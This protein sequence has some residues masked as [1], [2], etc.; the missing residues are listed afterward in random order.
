MKVI[1]RLDMDDLLKASEEAKR[2]E[3]LGYDGLAA[4]EFAHDTLLRLAIAAV[5]TER[6]SLESR[7]AIAFPRSP[8]VMAG[9]AWDMQIYSKGRF[10]LGLG[11][12]VKAH[13]I[14]RFGIP[15]SAPGPKFRD[16]VLALRAIWDSWQDGTPLDYNSDH[17]TFSLMPSAFNPGPIPYPRPQVYM[18]GVNPYNL[19][20]AGAIADGAV[21]LTMNSPEYVRDVVRPYVAEGARSVGRDPRSVKISGGGFVITGGRKE[22]L[23]QG[24]ERVRLDIA[25]HSS[26]RTYRRVLETHGWEG[27]IPRLH[28]LSLEQK[29]DEMAQQVSDEMVFTFAAVGLYDEVA[30]LLK[31]RFDGLL[32]EIS[33]DMYSYPPMSDAQERR[34]LEELR[35]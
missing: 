25:F 8:M 15:W 10:K 28:A 24:M 12:Q 20:L 6:I 33:P 13:N 14:R 31:Q 11:T 5:A 3:D 27:L 35:S 1:R 18:A 4:H 22:D 17:Y 32:D 16:Y 19:K 21:V 7:V 29:W 2:I 23:K 30:S 9:C 26:T 34:F